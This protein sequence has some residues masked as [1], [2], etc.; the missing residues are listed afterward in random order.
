[1]ECNEFLDNLPLYVLFYKF[2]NLLFKTNLIYVLIY[3]SKHNTFNFKMYSFSKFR[4]IF[5]NLFN[6]LLNNLAI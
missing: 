6:K 1:M 5:I 2:N 3:L 4:V